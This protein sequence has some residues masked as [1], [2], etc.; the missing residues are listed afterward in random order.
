MN[1]DQPAAAPQADGL[2]RV[3]FKYRSSPA[4]LRSLTEGSVYFASPGQ[5]ND[6]LE[7]KFDHC[8]TADYIDRMDQSIAGIAEQI[9][10]AGGYRVP[11]DELAAF[12]TTY[13]RQNALFLEGT[14]RVGIYSTACRP[15]DQSMWAYYCDNSKGFCFEVEWTD[16][17]IREHKVAPVGITYTSAT[18]VHNR[19]EIFGSLLREE[20]ELHPDWMIDRLLEETRSEFFLFRFQMA[21][22]CRAVSVKHEDWAHEREVRLLTP[23]AGPLPILRQILKRV[24]YVRSD[25]P[26]WLQ[27]VGLLTDQYPDVE[28]VELQFRHTEPY[29]EAR[30]IS[31]RLVPVVE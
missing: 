13:E 1:P 14:Q 26:E 7:A 21:N 8:G 22:I 18:R 15:D 19:A 25:F 16:A 5:L 17:V 9:G 30:Q 3:S 4:A 28:L 31:A 20:A 2:R 11:D 6:C 23:R 12:Q 10:A 29:V 27:V 24:Y